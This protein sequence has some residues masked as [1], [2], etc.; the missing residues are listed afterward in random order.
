MISQVNKYIEYATPSLNIKPN[1]AGTQERITKKR[2]DFSVGQKQNVYL[3]RVF[4]S[5]VFSFEN[6]L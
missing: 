1:T 3:R 6:N 5:S 4:R 2:K